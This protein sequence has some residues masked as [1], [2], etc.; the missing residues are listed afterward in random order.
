M[1]GQINTHNFI[2]IHGKMLTSTIYSFQ[3]KKDPYFRH[4]WLWIFIQ[5]LWNNRSKW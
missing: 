2:D 5:Y 4:G 1:N 3:P